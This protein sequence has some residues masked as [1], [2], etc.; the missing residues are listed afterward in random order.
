MV[1]LFIKVE[2]KIGFDV[3]CL[4]DFY[5]WFINEFISYDNEYLVEGFM[6]FVIYIGVNDKKFRWFIGKLKLKS[7][8]L[9]GNL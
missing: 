5:S 8:F 6:K 9:E 2:R 4:K 7:I 1:Y 3:I